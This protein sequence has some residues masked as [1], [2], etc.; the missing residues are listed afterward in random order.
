MYVYDGTATTND[1][2]SLKSKHLLNLY[3]RESGFSFTKNDVTTVTAHRPAVNQ[4]VAC[5][6]SW[7]ERTTFARTAGSSR[8]RYPSDSRT[9][10][11]ICGRSLSAVV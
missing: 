9:R 8:S 4:N 3:H 1:V 11:I 5:R 6:P 2:V 10:L 7:Y